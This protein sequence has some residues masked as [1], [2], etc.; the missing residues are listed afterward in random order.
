MVVLRS[1]G[2]SGAGRGGFRGAGGGAGGLA[3]GAE[4]GADPA[5]GQFPGR[6]RGLPGQPGGGG[7]RAGEPELVPGGDDEPGP[8]VGRGG[9]AEQR[10]GPAEPLLEEPEAVLRGKAGLLA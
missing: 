9:V 7:Q 1:F 5:G 6:D 10:P 4:L 2:A 3:C 8:A